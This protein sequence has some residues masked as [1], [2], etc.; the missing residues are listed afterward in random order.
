MMPN[1]AVTGVGAVIGHGVV[2]SIRHSSDLK[3]SRIIGIDCNPDSA[4]FMYCD[5]HYV[6]NMVSSPGY[7]DELLDICKKEAVD[8]FIPLIEEEFLMVHD[9]IPRFS[10]MG[11]RVIL[12]P[13]RILEMFMD[14]YFTA[15]ALKDAGI[16]TPET[17]LFA[18]ENLSVIFDM[19]ERH[20]FPLLAKP[21]RG[22]S[23]KG[24]VFINSE[25]QIVMYM[26]ILKGQPY[27]IQEFLSEESEEYTCGVFKTP[28]M[29]E[30]YSIALKRK[31]LNGMTISAEVVFDD[32]L[33]GVCKDVACLFP[34]D[35]SLN[36]QVRKK[37]GVPHVFEIN[38]RYSST[39]YIRAMCGFND[40]E[41]GIQYILN[42]CAIEKPIIEKLKVIR[43]SEERC[44]SYS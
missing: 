25:Q 34:V 3:N 20:G 41:M 43:Y 10:E 5:R 29:S 38:P 32:S 9:N 30:P 21:R 40:V 1:I 36:V 13:R 27:V 31:L 15:M 2:K 37:N 6:G 26:D 12:Q 7:I 28:G 44:V 33:S 24:Q 39:S 23:S 8:V 35:G 4:G 22:R 42:H 16:P 11:T 14:K 19:A 18:P 17:L